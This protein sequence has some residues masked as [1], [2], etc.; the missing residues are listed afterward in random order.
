[1]WRLFPWIGKASRPPAELQYA[2]E[3]DGSGATSTLVMKE[4]RLRLTLELAFYQNLNTWPLG[5]ED[6]NLLAV[7]ILAEPD[8][9]SGT[10]KGIDKLS[11]CACLSIT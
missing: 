8:P 1:M 7:W 5:L 3:T 4:T 11:R 10:K 9:T 6:C 2:M